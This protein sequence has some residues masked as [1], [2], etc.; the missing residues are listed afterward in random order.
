MTAEGGCTPPGPGETEIHG[1]DVVNNR[2]ARTR[3]AAR[4]NWLI[5][6][7]LTLI[8]RDD[9]QWTVLYRDPNDGR[10][11]EETRPY[12]GMHGGGPVLL[13]VTSRAEAEATYGEIAD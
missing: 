5:A 12:G 8:K 9:V 10:F 3:E 11:W 6:T 4:A 13:R 2:W 7:V 1:W